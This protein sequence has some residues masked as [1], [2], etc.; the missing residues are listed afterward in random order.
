MSDLPE[1]LTPPDCDLR[2]FSRM[3]IDITRLRQSSFDAIIDDGAW[4]A[5][6]NLWFSAW[7]SVPAGSLPD[8]DAGLAKA[9]GL[10]RD[11]RTWGAIKAEALHG[12]TLCSDGR[13]YH[14]T[15]CEFVL[16]A[17][18]EK[19]LQRIS[20][21]A[22]NAKRWGSEF[23]P[24]PVEI[25]ISSAA[26]LLANLNPASKTIA[27]AMRKRSQGSPAGKDVGT[28]RHPTGTDNQSHRDKKTIPVGSLEKGTGKGIIIEEPNGSSPPPAVDHVGDA[29]ADYERMR[30]SL[31]PNARAAQLG[32]DRR[33]K[34]AARLQDVGGPDGWASVL[35]IVQSSPFLR[36]EKTGRLVAT[37]DWLLE[38][39][40]LRKVME[41]NYDEQSARPAQRERNGASSPID[42]VRQARDA[43]GLG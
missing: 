32:P 33:K 16:E 41:G 40:N 37:I 5:G 24:A 29:F 36:G 6:L 1:P 13:L 22:G 21:G 25:S 20:S 14:E 34:L 15:V 11:V 42:A 8:D 31:V 3:M 19:L 4:R 43:L 2:D 27:K 18:I 23:D 10:G 28:D 35:T 7:H 9:A 39:K 38:P 30:H 17:W 26:I 12:F